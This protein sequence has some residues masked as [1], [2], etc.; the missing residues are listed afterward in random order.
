MGFLDSSLAAATWPLG[1]VGALAVE[2]SRS[3]PRAPAP[4]PAPIAPLAS[5][6]QMQ[7]ACLPR[8]LLCHLLY[9]HTP[10]YA[11][12]RARA[13][14]L[15][16]DWILPL[17]LR[18]VALCLL[19]GALDCALLLWPAS[20]FYARMKQHKHNPAY[21]HL[22]SR[23]GTSS[24]LREAAWSCSTAAMAG[25]LEAGVLHGYATGALAG[26]VSDAWWA[27]A[28]TLV[29]MVT[30]FYTQNIQ[31]YTIH[32]LMHKWGTT[33]V[34]DI[35][36]WL[37]RHVHSLHHESKNP[38]AF[39]GISMHPVEAALYLSYALL[40]ALGGAHFMAFLYIKTNLI[41]AAMLCV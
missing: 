11:D 5:H 34:P 27:D 35:G 3:S 4:P 39:S 1:A 8:L 36:A 17:V 33:W 14:V 19:I 15:S 32:R 6:I 40:P 16:A 21:P 30:W 29:F 12:W 26:P 18:D 13:A 23:N 31:F 41:A 9:A 38:T 7:L 24:L 10:L 28:R 2:A 20:P 25:L 22:L 37:Y